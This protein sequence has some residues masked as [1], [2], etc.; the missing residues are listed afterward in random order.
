MGRRRISIS[1]ITDPRSRQVTFS[2]RKTGLLKKASELSRL[3]NC[4]IGLVIINENNKLTSFSS[5]DSGLSNIVTKYSQLSR[6]ESV[7]ET[8]FARDF[9][10]DESEDQ[11]QQEEENPVLEAP[12][13]PMLD[14][15]SPEMPNV[16]L[17]TTEYTGSTESTAPTPSVAARPSSSV[18]QRRGSLTS[19]STL[20]IPPD[21]VFD[22]P[23]RPLRE[24][25]KG[26]ESFFNDVSP[27]G[28]QAL[29]PF[30]IPETPSTETSRPDPSKIPQNKSA[31][32]E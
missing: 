22:I 21:P 14:S 13:M 23:Q 18:L 19:S 5:D 32:V 17:L 4:H 30:A 1:Y 29:S 3:C 31:R 10:K 2:K 25:P 27:L 24:S 6:Q 28:L 20:S 8:K 16:Q 12:P 9:L 7:I 11:S 26:W 15:S